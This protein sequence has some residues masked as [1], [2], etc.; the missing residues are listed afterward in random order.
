MEIKK[1]AFDA[2]SPADEYFRGHLFGMTSMVNDL[3]S[4]VAFNTP[5][6]L[7]PTIKGYHDTVVDAFARANTLYAE[8]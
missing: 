3:F 7:L 8:D 6:K 1:P 4:C 2:T 5:E